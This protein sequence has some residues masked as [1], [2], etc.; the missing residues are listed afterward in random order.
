MYQ[1]YSNG[2]SNKPWKKIYIKILFTVGV[3]AY[4]L[5]EISTQNKLKIHN[6]IISVINK[7]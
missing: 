4:I 5:N 3:S 7:V 6:S 2:L 1:I